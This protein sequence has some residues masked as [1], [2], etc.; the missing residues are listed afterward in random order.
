[1]D[2]AISGL[3]CCR[4]G[5]LG[6]NPGVMGEAPVICEVEKLGAVSGGELGT[7]LAGGG[8]GLGSSNGRITVGFGTPLR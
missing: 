5:G 8:V 6:L 7:F 2:R 3:G 4:G 1:M